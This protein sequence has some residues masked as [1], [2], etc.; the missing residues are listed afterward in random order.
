MTPC[1]RSGNKGTV[2]CRAAG[3]GG[4]EHM[5]VMRQ[6]VFTRLRPNNRMCLSV[7][8]DP[9]RACGT[10]IAGREALPPLGGFSLQSW[11]HTSCG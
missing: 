6:P 3:H 9:G 8:H 2:T 10:K 11:R 7:L 1:Q 5:A 4:T